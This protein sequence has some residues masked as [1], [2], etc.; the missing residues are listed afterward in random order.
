[1]IYFILSE[2]NSNFERS[3][4]MHILLE[5]QH[6]EFA[7]YFEEITGLREQA[8]RVFDSSCPLSDF[9]DIL[10]NYWEPLCR[11]IVYPSGNRLNVQDYEYLRRAF[12][13]VQK[14]LVSRESFEK[15]LEPS[16][17]AIDNHIDELKEMLS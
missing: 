1:M 13:A 15:F 11:W 2:A 5:V 4:F 17:Q 3:F 8:F 7:S 16:R 10:K 9:E 6:R 14:K 12:W